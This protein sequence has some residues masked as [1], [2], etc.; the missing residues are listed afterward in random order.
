M[1]HGGN[2]P[3]SNLKIS[4]VYKLIAFL[5][6][7]QRL[8]QDWQKSPA[9]GPGKLRK[10]TW[11]DLEKQKENQP[12]YP[13]LPLL[14][15]LPLNYFRHSTQNKRIRRNP[16]SW[17]LRRNWLYLS[18]IHHTLSLG[19][20]SPCVCQLILIEGFFS[21]EFVRRSNKC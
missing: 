20:S 7:L 8:K 10:K 19:L 13:C 9:L 1:C 17:P 12:N 21:V 5:K 2:C 18:P 6:T 15:V 14:T 16:C 3:F 4:K 11:F